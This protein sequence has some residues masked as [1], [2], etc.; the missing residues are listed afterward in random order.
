ML[1]CVCVPVQSLPCCR[2]VVESVL[3]SVPTVGQSDHS[4]AWAR[5]CPLVPAGFLCCC[6]SH[7]EDYRM[8]VSQSVIFTPAIN[9][10][11]VS[12]EFFTALH[13]LELGFDS[14]FVIRF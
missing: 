9:M 7:G 10:C 1:I 3:G 11:F 14:D 6:S 4:Q 2:D 12:G 13:L 8:K 5:T